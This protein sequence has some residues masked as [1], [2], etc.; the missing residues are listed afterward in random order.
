MSEQYIK[1]ILESAVYDVAVET[2]IHK[3]LFLS[4]ALQNNVLVK[5]ED[6]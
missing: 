5:R 4:S 2:P 1:K 3:M 6:L